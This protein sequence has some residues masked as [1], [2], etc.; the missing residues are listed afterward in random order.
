[1]DKT[2]PH[3]PFQREERVN[4]KRPGK[5]NPGFSDPDDTAAHGRRLQTQLEAAK[6]Q[7]TEDQGGFDERRLFCFTV[8]KG[9]NPDDL[10]KIASPDS[11]SD[12]ELVSQEGEEIVVAFVSEAALESFEALLATLAQGEIPTNASVSNFTCALPISKT[13]AISLN[14]LKE[15]RLSQFSTAV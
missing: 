15:C 13:W 11:R 3:L 8:D 12:I 14:R 5:R 1:M 9:F 6:V 4:E 2:F 10:A 7:T